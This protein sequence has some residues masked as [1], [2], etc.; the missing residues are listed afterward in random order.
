MGADAMDKPATWISLPMAGPGG[1][2]PTAVGLA[3][4]AGFTLVLFLAIAHYAKAP[5]QAPP[6]DV[7]PLRVVIPLE[8]PPPP[9]LAPP[10]SEPDVPALAGL[11]LSPSDSPVRISASPP[12][13]LAASPED[14]S[15]I[16]PPDAHIGVR[17][18]NFKP[19]MESLP[20]PR[21]V[22]NPGDV[23]QPPEVLVRVSPNIPSSISV[24]AL[25]LSTTVLGIIET[26][27]R[28][29][30]VRVEKSSGN[31]HFDALIVNNVYQWSFSAA[32]KRGRKVRCIVEQS[33][34]VNG[35]ANSPFSR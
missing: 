7:A 3:L 14:L 6:A 33:V 17:L 19:R 21:E 1:A 31:P 2:A 18:M 23:D 8:P 16:P 32:V 20:D 25:S 26:N 22:F 5:F 13:E 24:T 4:G 30:E 9:P 35:M 12:L 10:E 27:G 34:T 11:E 15:R 29:T 28:I